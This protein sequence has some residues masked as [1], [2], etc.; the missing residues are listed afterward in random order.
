[1]WSYE[2][3]PEDEE[4]YEK[5]D[6][7]DWLLPYWEVVEEPSCSGFHGSKPAFNAVARAEGSMFPFQSKRLEGLGMLELLRAR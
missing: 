2:V 1:V 5:F 4:P 6:F 3:V 7:K